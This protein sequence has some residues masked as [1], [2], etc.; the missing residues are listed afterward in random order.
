MVIVPAKDAVLKPLV[1][2]HYGLRIL[3]IPDLFEA[4]CWAIMGQ[5]INVQFAY[6]LKKRFV[7]SFGEKFRFNEKVFYLFPTPEVISKQTVAKLRGLQF[8]AI[9]SESI[10]E[11]AKKMESGALSR[12][13]LLNMDNFKSAKKEL[14]RKIPPHFQLMI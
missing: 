2:K 13:S 7:E 5:H 11:I 1:D 4:I 9:K 12:N 10:I 8:T 6:I 14:M 3:T